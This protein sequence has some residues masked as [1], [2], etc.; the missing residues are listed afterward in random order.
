MVLPFLVS[1]QNRFS[2]IDDNIEMI[3]REC[4]SFV[5]MPGIAFAYG[6]P[7]GWCGAR[8][9]SKVRTPW[10]QQQEPMEL[11]Q[12]RSFAAIAETGQLT[13][14]AEKLHVSQPALSAQLK[15]LEEELDCVL[16]DRTPNGMVLTAAGR[17]MLADTENVLGAVQKLQNNA[18]ALKGKV[19][20]RARIG[21]LSDP[22]YIRLGE[23]IGAA[24][25][26]HPLLELEL[27]Q[28]VTGEVL[29]RVRD[30]QLD[31]SFYYG[32]IKFS[33]V[34]GLTL[35][36]IVYRVAVPAAWCERLKDAD[37]NEIASQPWIIPPLISTHNQLVHALLR[38]HGV[39]PTRVVEAD[40][41]A[42]VGS[43][44]VSGV[45]I[46]LM[47]EDIALEKQARGELCLW[48]DISIAAKLWFIYLREREGDPVIRA[49]LDVEKEIWGLEGMA[50]A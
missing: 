18:S 35:R 42:V 10:Q 28:G 27:H 8:H 14:A 24:T 3:G 5:W 4:Q 37:W 23:F 15:A 26:R 44:V 31:A 43:L 34:A 20:G 45:G 7:A 32:D 17:R 6:G 11:Y 38:E 13:R 39:E 12:L 21:T 25:T 9:S 2:C 49:L 19:V 22:E 50:L 16:F 47:R 29:E 41:E 40:H 1:N 48:N 46:A 36:G 33:S 30:G